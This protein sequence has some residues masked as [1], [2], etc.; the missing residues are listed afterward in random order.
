VIVV[1]YNSSDLLRV[2]LVGAGL[3]SVASIIVV[4]NSTDATESEEMAKLAEGQGW[5][6]LANRSNIGFG[7]AVN[8][9][10]QLALQD[11][12]THL[13][14]LNPDA[15]MTV[16]DATNLIARVSP[17]RIVAPRIVDEHDHVWFAGGYLDARRGIVRHVEGAT[18]W[19]TG[20]CL[21]IHADSWKALGGFDETYFLYWEDVDISSRWRALGGT[22]EVAPDAVAV[23]AVGGTQANGH[24]GKSL[25]YVYYNCRNRLV[26][27]LRGQGF[28][29]WMSVASRTPHYS[30]RLY[31]RARPAGFR[32]AALTARAVI[33]GVFAGISKARVRQHAVGAPYA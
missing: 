17:E 8:R 30:W 4:D 27:S 18:D 1:S 15:S 19:L 28:A 24:P 16:D 26:F 5:R 3:E 11:G 22:L 25:T 9:G 32:E 33:A 14:L 31:R 13:V 2:N 29:Q 12:A 10:A 7:A 21:A 6:L 20:A 23:H